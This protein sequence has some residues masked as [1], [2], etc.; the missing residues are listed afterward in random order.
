MPQVTIF[1]IVAAFCG[2]VFGAI[3]GG[4]LSF[5]LMG[6]LVL[7]GI[8]TA[9]TGGGSG[10]LANVAWG[11]MF[12]PHIGLLGGAIA[13][14]YAYQRGYYPDGKQISK[15]LITLKRFD[16][17]LVGGATGIIGYLFVS[18]LEAI[19]VLGDHLDAIA[20]AISL[21]MIVGRLA[22]GKRGLLGLRD[23]SA[24]DRHSEQTAKREL[25]R[26]QWHSKTSFWVPYQH[27]WLA[28]VSQGLVVGALAA[29]LTLLMVAI[30][31]DAAAVVH[32]TAF[33]LSAIS[34]IGLL[35]TQ[36]IPITHHLTLPAATAVSLFII[37]ATADF[38]NVQSVMSIIAG[39][40]V[41]AVVG[42]IGGIT[43]ELF[44]RLWLM[45]GDTLIDPPTLTNAV[46]LTSLAIAAAP[47]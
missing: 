10:F 19:P 2:G 7:I 32:E 16:I 21:T 20:V 12:G 28:V 41:G 27:S 31:P 14:A 43:C 39:A 22:F 29:V 23:I 38:G 44:A 24:A 46:L 1:G 45:R 5:I 11:P 33:A 17:L 47:R 30:F 13:A 40:I 3:I 9:I 8:V 26:T 15:S 42:A 35:A 37:P 36:Y 6:M 34:L 4:L 18:A 25:W